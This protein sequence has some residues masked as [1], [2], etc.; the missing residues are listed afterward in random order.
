MTT[1]S[2]DG[3]RKVNMWKIGKSEPGVA[4]RVVGRQFGLEFALWFL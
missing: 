4:Y 2:C 3:R 1:L